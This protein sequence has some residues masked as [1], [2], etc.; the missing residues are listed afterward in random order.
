MSEEEDK[1]RSLRL[2]QLRSIKTPTLEELEERRLLEAI[3]IEERLIEI[4]E[5]EMNES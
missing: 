2:V 5:D 1:Q 4:I 3:E